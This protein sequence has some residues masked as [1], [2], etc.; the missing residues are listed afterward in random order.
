MGEQPKVF[1]YAKEI[2]METLAL[3]DKIREWQLPVRS[4]MVAL[5]EEMIVE[6]EH[7][8]YPGRRKKAKK[9]GKKI[10]KKVIKK[11][12]ALEKSGGRETPQETTK[13]DEG[14]DERQNEVTEKTTKKKMAKKKTGAK[15]AVTKKDAA[16]K[17]T[18]KKATTKKTVTKKTGAKKVVAQKAVTK[19]AAASQ[20]EPQKITGDLTTTG[21]EHEK[22]KKKRVVIRRRAD[23]KA[24][25][26]AAATTSES[27][28]TSLLS[29]EATDSGSAALTSSS[30]MDSP[31]LQASE[32]S[33]KGKE[34][35]YPAA[36]E[37]E[38]KSE[39]EVKT[40]KNIVGRMDLGKIQGFGRSGEGSSMR[41]Q[42]TVHRNIRTGFVAMPIDIP[43]SPES[44]SREKEK[45]AKKKPSAGVGKEQPVQTFAATEFRKREVIF[46]PKK[47]R[48]PI[49]REGKKNQLTT[50]KASKR[51]VK[52]HNVIKVSDLAQKLG[53]KH[54][55]LTKK[56]ISEGVKAN[57][58]TELDFD[59]VSLVVPEFGFEAENLHMDIDERVKHVAFGDLD[60]EPVVRPPVVTVMGHVDHGKTTL[61]DAIRSSDVVS[62][63]AGGI[64]QHIG[65]YRVAL[66]D[67]KMATFIDTPGHAAFT[68]MRAR[69]ANVTDIVVL[70]VAADDGVMPQTAEAINH[71]K[72]AEVP[73]IVAVNKVDRPD[74]NMERIKQQLME[75]ELIPEEWGGRTLFVEVSALK[76]QGIENLIEQIHLQAE[77]LELRANPKRSATGTVIEGSIKKGRGNVATLL[78]QEGTLRVGDFMVVG[79][80]MGRVRRLHNELG[81][82]LKEAGP[83]VP[84]EVAGIESTPQAGDRF[85]V[86]Q[87]EGLAHEIA[88]Q[89]VAE[90]QKKVETPHAGMSLEEIF[91]KVKAGNVQELV[92]VLK[93][94]V[95]GSNEAIKGMLAKLNHEEVKVNIIHSG[96][97]GVSESDILLA[98][99]SGG[100]VIGFNVRPDS[101]AQRMA[102]EKG[103]EIKTYKII[104]EL[105]DDVKK[106]LSGLLRPDIVEKSQGQAEVRE[107]FSIPR[108]GVIAGCSVV[109]GK[110]YRT[111]KLRLIRDGRVVYEGTLGSLKR[112]KD[113]AKEVASGYECGIGIENYNDIKV[114]DVI[115]AYIEEEVARTLDSLES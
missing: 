11:N 48:F 12:V 64:T 14:G 68:E 31:E 26:E 115:E 57:I 43:P 25:E 22:S 86:C 63:E 5:S 110:I 81:V 96:V 4:H 87:E 16:K 92:I 56:L 90:V 84:V 44:E 77:V 112:Y 34:T 6:I 102:K 24:A 53:V 27:V 91:S 10:T 111:S 47:R 37:K 19:G 73:V 51:I 78:V 45:P 17:A 52:V 58:N 55:Q 82:G 1:E 61:L 103:V 105:I 93:S 72:A 65:A 85:D 21:Q 7:R 50:P 36:K 97:G 46:Q 109:D 106:A 70:V 54:V 8:L 59:T 99:T 42:R 38:G 9:A 74:A 79:M 40:R 76:K 15:K 69:G 104:Y 3:M 107:I 60:A 95:V 20:V 23:V 35:P 2:G 30:S 33:S 29:N 114:G 66:P 32:S 18:T 94:D 62:G 39:G 71:A 98:N 108:L 89:R 83:G 49:I 100:V 113:D 88:Q 13:K 101:S 67:G 41:P 80:T 75:Y 28:N